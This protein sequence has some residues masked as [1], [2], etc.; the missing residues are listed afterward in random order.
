MT[1]NATIVR[2][3]PAGR[4]KY[5]TP[6]SGDTRTNLDGCFVAPRSSEDTDDRGRQGVVVGMSLYGP[7]GTDLVHTDLVEVDGV[8]YELEGDPG[9]WKNPLTGWEAG[10]EQAI[11]RAAG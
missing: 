3:R 9:Q 5:G 6:L 1:G 2:I 4:D 11:R 7:Y 10:F 8:R